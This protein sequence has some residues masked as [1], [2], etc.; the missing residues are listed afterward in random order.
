MVTLLKGGTD[1]NK[2]IDVH[3]LVDS[4]CTGSCID[5][6]FVQRYDLPTKKYVTPMRVLN[7]DGTGNV[8]GLITDYLETEMIVGNH[9]EKRNEP[10]IE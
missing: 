5:E 4:G 1:N 7:A 10:R 9:R 3:A 6:E 2:T 8:G